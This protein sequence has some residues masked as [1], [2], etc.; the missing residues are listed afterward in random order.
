MV[1]FVGAGCSSVTSEK[2][3]VNHG[4]AAPTQDLSSQQEKIIV[5]N[6][7]YSKWAYRAPMFASIFS[8]HDCVLIEYGNSWKGD[9]L[10]S[11]IVDTELRSKLKLSVYT[12]EY[13]KKI[14]RDFAHFTQEKYGSDFY[15]F[16][17]CHVADV[18][19]A[20]GYL[21]AQGK[22]IKSYPKKSVALFDIGHTVHE[23]AGVR[24]WPIQLGGAE[25]YP[26]K[27]VEKDGVSN[28]Q[29][30]WTSLTGTSGYGGPFDD[31][32]H[33]I[34]THWIFDYN[35]VELKK[36]ETVDDGAFGSKIDPDPVEEVIFIR[37]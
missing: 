36:F 29:I 5:N 11:L 23:F 31:T 14:E 30:E 17:I 12:P 20:S 6:S 8:E 27:G 18:D 22:H 34:T 32:F 26:N 9:L 4:V 15:A 24:V 7:V 37:N 10:S 33:L 25:L 2:I 3:D 19:V 35:G 16:N 1:V 21:I 28:S 13:L